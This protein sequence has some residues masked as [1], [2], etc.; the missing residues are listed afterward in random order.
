MIDY[1]YFL[2]NL[3]ALH[4][5]QCSLDL[6]DYKDGL[7]L[8]SF[9]LMDKLLASNYEEFEKHIFTIKDGIL[10]CYSTEK[11]ENLCKKE[12]VFIC[13]SKPSGFF[14]ANAFIGL[15]HKY[16]YEITLKENCY[17]IDVN[18][19]FE[20]ECEIPKKEKNE[21]LY[22]YNGNVHSSE[23]EVIVKLKDV[24]FKRIS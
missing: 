7:C 24:E 3:L 22:F 16:S 18:S 20:G 11:I 12:Q 2:R 13:C 1:I 4:S 14:N 8:A 9:G 17:G 15:P 19:F 21:R 5:N 6:R 23:K 10:I